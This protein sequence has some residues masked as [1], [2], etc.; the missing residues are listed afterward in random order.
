MWG[1]MPST[2]PIWLSRI[3]TKRCRRGGRTSET[4][5]RSGVIMR[6]RRSSRGD[7]FIRN[8][9]GSCTRSQ[10]V[11]AAKE[12]VTKLERELARTQQERTEAL[13]RLETSD[14]ELNEVQGDL[15]EAQKQLKEA[16]VRARKVD[17][18]LLKSMK[19]LESAQAELPK[20]AIDDY[21][22]STS[23]KEGLKR[24]GRVAYEYDYWV[25]L[26]GFRSSHLDSK[27]EEDPFT[28]RPEDDS[29]PMERQ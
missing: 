27:V 5:L 10:A 28:I 8:W 7:S 19:D 26:A 23:F 13:Q 25:A 11:A 3:Q 29:I 9:R 6:L 21:N 14:K 24:M 18:D 17:N 22:G 4:R 2:C 20:Q 12:R 16:R 1:I 15:S